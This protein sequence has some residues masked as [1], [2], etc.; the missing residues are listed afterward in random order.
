MGGWDSVHSF[1]KI[2]CFCTKKKNNYR[3]NIVLKLMMQMSWNWRKILE[4]F[5][6]GQFVVEKVK[7]LMIKK[8]CWKLKEAFFNVFVCFSCRAVGT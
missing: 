6:L 7:K 3:F 5:I 8:S 4:F 2:F 1:A